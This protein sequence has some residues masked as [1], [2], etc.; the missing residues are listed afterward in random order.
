[1][2]KRVKIFILSLVYKVCLVSVNFIFDDSKFDEFDFGKFKIYKNKGI[3]SKWS[4]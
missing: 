4:E 1:M 2:N 3:I